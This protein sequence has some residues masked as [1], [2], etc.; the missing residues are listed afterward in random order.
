MVPGT[1]HGGGLPTGAGG[2]SL[3]RRL[4]SLTALTNSHDHRPKVASPEKVDQW[5]PSIHIV[6]SN[7]KRFVAGTFHGVSHRY[8]QE[9]ID[10]FVYRFNRRYWEPQLPLMLFQAAVDH[11]PVRL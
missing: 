7:F 2:S 9:Y 1:C 8:L 6:I 10:E 11:A 3:A 5:L 4:T